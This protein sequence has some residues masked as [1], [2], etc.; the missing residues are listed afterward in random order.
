[1]QAYKNWLPTTFKRE[2]SIPKYTGWT[3]KTSTPSS[4]QYNQDNQIQYQW[5]KNPRACN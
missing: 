2:V 3:M 1:M 4:K 5:E